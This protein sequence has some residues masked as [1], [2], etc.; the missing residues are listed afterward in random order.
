MAVS[1][2]VTRQFRL[3]NNPTFRR[4]HKHAQKYGEIR[5]RVL[6]LVLDSLISEKRGF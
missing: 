4:T 5:R 2:S 1:G 6:L 3:C